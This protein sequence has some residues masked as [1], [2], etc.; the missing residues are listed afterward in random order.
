MPY[1]GSHRNYATGSH[2]EYAGKHW[3]IVGSH[4]ELERMQKTLQLF[5][6]AKLP[7]NDS[8]GVD[9]PGQ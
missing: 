5:V 4:G 3:R 6:R 7:P 2:W 1:A 9:I 8:A